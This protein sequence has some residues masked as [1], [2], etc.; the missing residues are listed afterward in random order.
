MYS[1]ECGPHSITLCMIA[2]NEEANIANAIKSVKDLV[3]E[4]VVVDTG[5]TDNTKSVVHDLGGRLYDYAWCD[6]FASAR[7]ESLK[8]ARCAWILVLDADEVIAKRDHQEIRKAIHEE[9]YDAICFY[10]RNYF[11]DPTAENWCA[12]ETDYEEGKGF[13]GYSDVPVFRLFRNCDD[14]FF[15]GIVHEVIDERL[16]VKRKHYTDIPIH[17]YRQDLHDKNAQGKREKYLELLVKAYE[18]DPYDAKTCFLL[19]RQLYD[20]EQYPAAVAYLE[21]AVQLGTQSEIVHSNL[22]NAYVACGMHKEAIAVLE[23]LIQFNPRYT[24]A[25]AALGVSYYE[26]GVVDKAINSLVK[27]I[28][29]K[30]SAMKYYYNLAVI[31]YKEHDFEGTETNLKQA[32]RLC[33]KFARAY[34]LFFFMRYQQGLWEKAYELSNIIKR[35]DA[36]LYGYIKDKV[37][38]IQAKMAPQ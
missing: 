31:F 38:E 3:N 12:N 24:E 10:Q 25:Y 33:P 29:L 21:R 26:V 5:S 13:G 6:D 16:A 20:F 22:S 14:I 19:G 36:Q 32:V 18:K 4:I 30:P 23:K 35:M 17:H 2:K 1:N 34:Y 9:R 27:A 8:Y 28:S 15:E 37:V 11:E 7:N